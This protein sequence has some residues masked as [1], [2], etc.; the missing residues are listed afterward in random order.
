MKKT[1][2]RKQRVISKRGFKKDRLVEFNDIYRAF[3]LIGIY[4]EYHDEKE[5]FHRFYEEETKNTRYY[6]RNRGI[7]VIYQMLCEDEI[8]EKCVRDFSIS[9]QSMR[10]T[11]ILFCTVRVYEGTDDV[12]KKTIEYIVKDDFLREFY[13]HHIHNDQI[14]EYLKFQYDGLMS[15]I[16]I[17]YGTKAKCFSDIEKNIEETIKI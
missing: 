12:V 4:N 7:D 13:T 17:H 8:S 16:G 1:S 14:P 5:Y 11:G 3:E 9:K 6:Y 2:K 10:K 15:Y